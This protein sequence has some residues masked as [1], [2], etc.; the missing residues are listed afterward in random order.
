MYARNS[1]IGNRRNIRRQPLPRDVAAYYVKPCL[2]RGRRN[3]LRL[4]R[5]AHD[6]LDRQRSAVEDGELA[7]LLLG[8]EP[9]EPDLLVVCD[10]YGVLREEDGRIPVAAHGV[11]LDFADEL[12]C[13]AVITAH[14]KTERRA[15]ILVDGA[16]ER[17]VPAMNTH[18]LYGSLLRK[19]GAHGL[20]SVVGY[21]VHQVSPPSRESVW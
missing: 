3:S 13:P 8:I 10:E 20:L 18:P 1:G 15:R 11:V 4:Q 17:I 2:G 9:A 5:L 14:A 7:P 21:S 19:Y 12:P 6:L 16:W